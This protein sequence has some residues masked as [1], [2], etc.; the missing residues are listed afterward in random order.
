MRRLLKA[1]KR[2]LK[3]VRVEVG[4]I[5][6]QPTL[7]TWPR[8]FVMFGG[9]KMDSR[10]IVREF[11]NKRDVCMGRDYDEIRVRPLSDAGYWMVT[12]KSACQFG[13]H[14]Y[15]FA[16]LAHRKYGYRCTECKGIKS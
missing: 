16:K 12:I 7:L 10:E 9:D 15:K 4:Y 5:R 11:N 6:E 8:E 1:F 14:E 2:W 13:W 3:P